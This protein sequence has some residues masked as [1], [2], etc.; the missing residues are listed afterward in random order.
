[1]NVLVDQTRNTPLIKI[2]PGII[3]IR[4]RSI[5]ED[6][7]DFYEPIMDSIKKYV[8]D[9][10]KHTDIIIGLEYVNS[11]SKKYLIN[12][13]T[14]LEETVALNT[15]VQ[16]KW[17]IDKDDDSMRELGEDLNELIELPFEFINK[18]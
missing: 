13:L 15:K 10:P 5:P 16:V 3:E 2:Q 12:I 8:S 14:F 18:S 6:A 7:F 11:G 9:P 17:M 4:G 1:M